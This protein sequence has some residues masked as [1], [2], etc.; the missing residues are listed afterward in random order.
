LLDYDNT[1]FIVVLIRDK[2]GSIGYK[3]AA[4]DIC[5]Q[6]LQK[7]FSLAALYLVTKIAISRL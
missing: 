6:L 3:L 4:A 5:H 2:I 1:E 7:D